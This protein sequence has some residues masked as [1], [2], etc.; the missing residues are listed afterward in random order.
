MRRPAIHL[1]A[2]ADRAHLAWAFWRAA[3][4]KRH[5]PEVRRI[6]DNLDPWLD[7]LRVQ[8]LDGTVPLG[9]YHRFE[10]RD[11][12]PRTIH[13]PAFRERVLHHAPIAR[14]DPLFERHLVDD[15]FACRPGKGSRAAVL[16]AQHH[17]RRWRWYLKLDVRAYFASIDQGVLKAL[18]R[19]RIKGAGVL[20]LV[21]R[22]VDAYQVAPGRAGLRRGT[23][24][25]LPIGALTSQ[26]FANLYLAGL[27]RYLLEELRV[28]GMVRYMDDVVVWH[29]DRASLRRALAASRWFAAD[30]LR[31]ELKPGWQLQRVSRGL[32][33]C[34]FRVGPGTLRLTARRRRRYRQARARW[35]RAYS[36][37]R[38]DAAGLQAGYASALAIT[39]GADAAAWRRRELAARPPVEA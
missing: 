19:R 29:R 33:L 6:A 36:A 22:I 5:Q 26:H 37:G 21:D 3:L 20:A 2:V 4:G 23:H 25:G 16:R 13:A 32:S 34:G 11:P 38:I 8:I 7:L 18:I 10:I 1:D 15:T 9:R 28:G 31:L 30:R 39:D 17:S 27:D 35:E 24:V 12:K 14:L